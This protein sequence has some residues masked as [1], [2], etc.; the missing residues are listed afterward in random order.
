MSYGN[1]RKHTQQP[2][3]RYGRASAF[4]LVELLVVVV[5]I[6]ILMSLLLLVGGR[7][8]NNQ[9]R[10]T[11]QNTMRLTEM[12]I[13]QFKTTDPL[14]N[15]YDNP[16]LGFGSGASAVT[17]GRTFGPYPPY[18]LAN[19]GTGAADVLELGTYATAQQIAESLGARLTRDLSGQTPPPT[20]PNDWV[21][22]EQ[23][24]NRND[25]IR[26]LY[27]YL[28]AYT[29]GVLSQ[30][31]DSAKLRLPD[32]SPTDPHLER[33]NPTGRGTNPVGEG[34]IDVF[35]IYDA[36]GVPLDYFLQVK[37]EY[38]VGPDDSLHWIVTDRMPVLRSLGITKEEAAAE[39]G[40]TDELDPQK[41]IFSQP[42]PQPEFNRTGIDA[43]TGQISST[44][45]NDGGW[46]RVL[47][48]NGTDDTTW[49]SY[50]YVPGEG[51]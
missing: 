26:A 5:V 3:E 21:D 14:Q 18:Q 47:A 7:V 35:G 40:G 29:P 33:I 51:R 9:K 48:G 1:A 32:R 2:A 44:N 30:I 22:I 24:N 50:K 11:T 4:T 27:C 39:A 10:T 16:K 19:A 34:A 13:D 8:L 38:K 15:L 6:G 46:V 31:P 41:W 36:W 23:G 12:A 49:D 20:E 42:F 25:D 17:V 45:A 37:L 43:V 28:A